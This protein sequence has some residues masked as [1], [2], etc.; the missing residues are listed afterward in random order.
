MHCIGGHCEGCYATQ[1]GAIDH[2][3]SSGKEMPSSSAPDVTHLPA[4]TS[5]TISRTP[6]AVEPPGDPVIVWK[7][8]QALPSKDTISSKRI[9][10]RTWQAV[11]DPA[12][13]ALADVASMPLNGHALPSILHNATPSHEL[14]KVIIDHASLR[15]RS[16]SASGSLS[17]EETQKRSVGQLASGPSSRAPVPAASGEP[18]NHA[19]SPRASVESLILPSAGRSLI[20]IQRKVTE[21]ASSTSVSA[22]SDQPADCTP[23]TQDA[24]HTQHVWA[25]HLLQVAPGD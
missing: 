7:E 10:V 1:M 19:G 13:Q 20:A 11:D 24:R 8:Q 17:A 21:S 4:A 9:R 2:S 16:C 12:D 5:S 15:S 14:P 25:R 3:L 23:Q 18:H 22:S 6:P